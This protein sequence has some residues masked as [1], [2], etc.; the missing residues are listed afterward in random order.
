MKYSPKKKEV[1]VKLV[2]DGETAVLQ[3]K[4]KGMGISPEEIPKIFQRFYRSK[5]I[6]ASETGGSGLGL[7]LVKHIIE[8]HGGRIQVE[9]EP[10]EG[11]I[12]SVILPL[13]NP[14]R[15]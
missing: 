9:S 1:A 2:R 12:F 11:S 15:N 7:T 6:T 4:D 3:V 5:N 13:S 10:G 8:A 14:D